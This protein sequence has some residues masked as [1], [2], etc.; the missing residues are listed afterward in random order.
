MLAGWFLGL[1]ARFTARGSKN[2]VLYSTFQ[3][4]IFF[5]KTISK[6][7]VQAVRRYNAGRM[8]PVAVPVPYRGIFWRYT[9]NVKTR[10]YIGVFRKIFFYFFLFAGKVLYGNAK[11]RFGLDTARKRSDRVNLINSITKGRT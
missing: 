2:A 6:M 10:N 4:N 5:E 9:L 3:R 11:K 1:D 8:R 7:A